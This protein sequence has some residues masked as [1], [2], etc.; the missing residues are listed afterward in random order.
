MNKTLYQITGET[1]EIYNQLEESGGDLSPEMEEALI[2]SQTEL[3]TKGQ[4]YIE[5]L[6]GNAAFINNIDQ[7]IKRL[8]AMKKTRSNL[9]KRLEDRLLDAVKLFGDIDLGLTVITTR[10]SKAVQVEDVNS[11]PAEYKNIK[12]QEQADKKAIKEALEAGEQIKG[13]SIVENKSLR[14]K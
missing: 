8:Q 4:A 12:I 5:V 11:L 3:K 10:K 1:L 9:S 13:C 6:K 14:I 2:I 7:E